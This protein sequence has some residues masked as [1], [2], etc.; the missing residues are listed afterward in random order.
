MKLEKQLKNKSKANFTLQQLKDFCKLGN[1]SEDKE[2]LYIDIFF[3]DNFFKI[4]EGAKSS[5]K[6]Y[7]ICALFL[8]LLV[9]EEKWNGIVIR[10]Y[11]S[12][13][14]T[15]TFRT[16]EKIALMLD[17]KYKCNLINNLSF[18]QYK[19]HTEIEYKNKIISFF[20]LSG[21][22]NIGGITAPFGG[23]G[24]IFI[25]EIVE[26]KDT[27]YIPEDKIQLEQ[28]GLRM[29]IDTAIRGTEYDGKH[30][31]L[32]TASNGWNENH[33]FTKEYVLPYLKLTEENINILKK[34]NF[35]LYN[36]KNFYGELGITICKITTWVNKHKSELE[37]KKAT[38]LLESDEN[39]YNA[40]VLGLYYQFLDNNLIYTECL[41]L[42]KPLDWDFLEENKNYIRFVVWSSD[43][44]KNDA[45]VLLCN[46]VVVDINYKITDWIIFKNIEIKN[47]KIKQ[48]DKIELFIETISNFYNEYP[49][50]LQKGVEHYYTIDNKEY[51]IIELIQDKIAKIK[52]DDFITVCPSIKNNVYWNIN[53]R[54]NTIKL[55]IFEGKIH[56][57]EECFP[58]IE[59][60]KFC[61]YDKSKE[62][63]DEIHS[64]L[65]NINALEY[66]IGL[67]YNF[68]LG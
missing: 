58:L 29:I 36:D 66:A 48:Q 23:Y 57:S 41:P 59:E 8:Y 19:T 15:K 24:G 2:N 31:F 45:T 17:E 52:L 47:S 7:S 61:A 28:D 16:F 9:N 18:N 38:A 32:I 1:V 64:K 30:K 3:N 53:N 55:M 63:R 56:M 6:T 67:L 25:D 5:G 35:L 21:I 50:L 40:S 39:Y 11:A 22:S 10:K 44:G 62:E 4:F 46:L 54:I 68:V 27:S 33:W 51:T 12:D 13:H 14:K 43:W 26:M 34:N 42:I 65:D 49:I 20:S 37:K 60:L